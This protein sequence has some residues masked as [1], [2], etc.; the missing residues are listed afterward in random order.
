MEVVGEFFGTT[1]ASWSPLVWRAPTISTCSPPDAAKTGGASPT[2]PMSTAPAGLASNSGG[3][4]GE[5]GPVDVERQRVQQAGRRQDRLGAR[6][7]LV[8][9]VQRHRGKVHRTGRR[10]GGAL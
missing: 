7:L 2:P 10:A 8:A 4:G 3:A 9:D 1:T 6:P 5:V